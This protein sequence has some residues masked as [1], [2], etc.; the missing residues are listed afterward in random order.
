MPIDLAIDFGT[1][2]TVLLSG[3]K[4]LL[5]QPSVAT[6]DSETWEPI[7]FGERAKNMIGRLPEHLETVFPIKRG[8]VADYDLAEQMLT[9][10][11]TRA[12]DKHL[13]K[14]RV[15]IAMPSGAN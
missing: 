7:C 13:I 2:K 11:M 6:V 3:N 5:E 14:P 9:E 8:M 4:I 1:S 10:F 15:I 12:L